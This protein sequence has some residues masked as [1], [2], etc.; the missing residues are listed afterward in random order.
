[1]VIRSTIV[2]LA[3]CLALPA[4]AQ[5]LKPDPADA[6]AVKALLEKA[7]T[8]L[9][10]MDAQSFVDCCDPYV[11]CFFVEGTRAKGKATIEDTL[12]QYFARRPKG[13]AIQL[14]PIP[15]SFR[16]LSKEIITVDWPAEIFEGKKTVTVNTLTTLRKVDGRWLITSYLESAPYEGPLGGRNREP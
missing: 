10:Q 8:A 2:V 11:E 14:R 12:G 6:E 7:T 13:L 15:R 5:D 9:G 16:V 4:V 3:T 1:M